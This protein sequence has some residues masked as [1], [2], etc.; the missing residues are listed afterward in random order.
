MGSRL[1]PLAVAVAVGVRD[2]SRPSTP[3]CWMSHTS[4]WVGLIALVRDD[5]STHTSR[6]MA[7]V[8][9]SPSSTRSRRATLGVNDQVGAWG[10]SS[11][12]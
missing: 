2:S 10:D 5:L 1:A 6:A 3:H 4:N 7:E 11:V 8:I 12:A 9:A